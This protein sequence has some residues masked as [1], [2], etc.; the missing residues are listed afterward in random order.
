MVV[1]SSDI[2]TMF[3]RRQHG[4]Q[5]YHRQHQGKRGTE[6]HLKYLDPTTTRC[7]SKPGEG[8][9][10]SQEPAL[11]QRLKEFEPCFSGEEKDNYHY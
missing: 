5:A 7:S 2:S 11:G 3:G 4:A 1:P 9:T 6:N 10:K 8:I